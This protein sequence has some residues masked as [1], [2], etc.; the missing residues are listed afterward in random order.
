MI[1]GEVMALE[2]MRMLAIGGLGNSL[3]ADTEHWNWQ[4]SSMRN[5]SW[6]GGRG[7]I[8]L[9]ASQIDPEVRGNALL[10]S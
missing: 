10:L 3:M 7:A 9:S 6:G 5:E 2:N 1:F 4:V 8:C